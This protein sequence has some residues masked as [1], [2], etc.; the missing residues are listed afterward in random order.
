MIHLRLLRLIPFVVTLYAQ[1][2]RV[3]EN[4]GSGTSR[5]ISKD[6]I[7]SAL[8]A[9]LMR[10]TGLSVSYRAGRVRAL[11]DLPANLPMYYSGQLAYLELF[12]PFNT[13][14]SPNT[15]L[16]ST[17]ADLDSRVLRR[18]LV[19]PVSD[20]VFACHLVPKFYQLGDD[21]ELHA[22]TDSLSI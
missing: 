21:I 11:F 17:K 6:Q 19:V 2:R 14:P 5:Y 22:Y 7:V 10:S 18:T 12:A 9:M 15:K 1:A 3:P 4:L 20:I 8:T 16:H 13:H